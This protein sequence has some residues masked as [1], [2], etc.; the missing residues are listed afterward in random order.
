[1]RV[2]F[3]RLPVWLMLAPA[4]L[5][6]RLPLML[7]PAAGRD[8]AAYYYWAYHNELAYS[9]LLQMAVWCADQLA[10]LP[11]T[12]RLRLPSLIGGILVLYVFDRLLVVRGVSRGGRW[13][14]ISALAFT[15]WQAYAGAILHP[16]NLLLLF[17]FLTVLWARRGLLV[18]LAL[19]AAAALWA[20]PTGLLVAVGAMLFLLFEMRPARTRPLIATAIL[21]ILSLPVLL[22]FR[23][24]MVT[25]M[26]EFG[27]IGGGLSA[28][29]G[30]P[31]IG[32]IIAVCVSGLPTDCRR[33]SRIVT[34]A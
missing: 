2:T 3:S 8:E 10:F 1:M 9:P 25:A 6:L 16:D 29:G 28:I 27:Q 21:I 18:P 22:A 13:L 34:G 11:P 19:A 23:P 7:L 15:P 24:E 5:L 12:V 20:K 17:M 31:M 14:A 32:I 26:S 30:W 33:S 4:A